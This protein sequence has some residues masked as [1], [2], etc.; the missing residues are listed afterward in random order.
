MLQP[1][2]VPEE[3]KDLVAADYDLLPPVHQRIVQRKVAPSLS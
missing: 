2:L 1:E 3:P